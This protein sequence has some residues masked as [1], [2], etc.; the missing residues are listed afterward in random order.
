MRLNRGAA[1]GLC[2]VLATAC[3]GGSPG[4][5]RS[6]ID[7][8]VDLPLTGPEARAAQPALNGIQF[9][10]ARHPS[11]DGYTVV[12]TPTDD[13]RGEA[14]NPD[15]GLGDIQRFIADQ[16]LLAVLG[17][18][19]ASV[20]RREIPAA[21]AAGLALVSP[22]TSSPCLTRDVYVPPA[23]NPAGTA[24][25]CKEAG[26]PT[27]SALR[28]TH[29]NDYFRLTTTDDLQGPA[30][31]DYATKT[32]HLV[33]VGVLSDHEA[34]GQAL[35]DSFTARLQRLGGTVVGHLDLN[36]AASTDTTAWLKQMKA[37]G[38]QAIYFGG[39]TSGKGCSIRSAMRD[40]FGAGEAAPFLGGD[41][42]A[43]DPACVTAAG[44]NSPGIFATVP[45]VDAATASGAAS[46][47]SAFK[48][49][50]RN[51]RDYGPYTVVAY[52]AAAVLYAALDRAIRAAGGQVPPRGN[53][54]S[55][56]TV[57]AGFAGATGPIGFDAAGDTTHRVVSIY[58]PAGSDPALPWRFVQAIDYSAA[59]PY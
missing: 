24:V 54:V 7:I 50:Y 2:L 44:S 13:A 36:P 20:A 30:A 6:S 34:Y 10:F 45:I 56:L 59:L 47:I 49:A 26:L 18:F 35:A 12:L 23:L 3:S 42:I 43:D 46:V 32:L 25:T 37:A 21:N 15:L 27:A 14:A 8:G 19:D 29:L 28:P 38:A 22:A 57:T 5:P 4:G 48:A 33:R 9:F 31:A 1:A 41:G 40:V 39:A 51:A 53:V 16:R 55:Q 11:V 58:E 17:P 52:D